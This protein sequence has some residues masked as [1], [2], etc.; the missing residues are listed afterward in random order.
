[1]YA[2]YIDESGHCGHKYNPAQPVE[3]LV[4]VMNNLGTK[5]PKTQREFLQL[6]QRLTHRDITVSELK[7]SQAYRGQKAWSG[8]S[9][10][11]R[12]KLF[13][14]IL[15]WAA[16]RSCKYF[17]APIDSRLFFE[18][19]AADCAIANRLKAPY[20]AGAMNIILAIEREKSGTA[21][22]KGM[23][24]VVFDEQKALDEDLKRL[25]LGDLA[26]TDPYTGYEF[27]TRKTYNPPRLGQIF[28]IPYFSPSHGSVMIQV[29]D[30]V[31][32]VV[33]KYLLLT[34]YGHPEKFEGELEQ[35]TRWY[36]IVGKCLVKHTAIE[37]PG[38]D[39]I[40]QFFREVRP[41]GWS[42]KEWHVAPGVAR[43]AVD[44]LTQVRIDVI[45][46]RR[47]VNN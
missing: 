5:L 21:N 37:P 14:E 28:D 10:E 34:V 7:A 46:T 40:V 35:I 13:E 25:L 11:Q 19:K 12:M 23:T 30:W 36:G 17:V 2:C 4:G 8:V 45:A 9:D 42:A 29:A 1:M 41:T 20:I 22:N 33:N 27:S 26:W 6:V 32:F 38:K 24:W 31:A 16:E 15:N 3:V 44:A 43:T 47:T 18:R 39:A